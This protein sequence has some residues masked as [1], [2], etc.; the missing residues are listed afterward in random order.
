[1]TSHSD[2]DW[3]QTPIYYDM[4][5]DVGSSHEADFLVGA[6][7]KHHQLD[8]IPSPPF[9]LEPACGSGRLMI[10]MHRRGWQPHGFDAHPGMIDFARHRFRETGTKAKVWLDRMECFQVPGKARYPLAHCLV[11]TF[12]YLLTEHD[13]R[14]HLHAVGEVLLPGG[15]Y[16][17]GL[18]LSDYAR[19]TCEHERWTA[20]RDGM[21]V[22]CNIRGWPPNPKTREEKVRSRLAVTPA[23]QPVQRHE[24]SWIFRTYNA[25]QLKR[26]LG[27][28]ASVFDLVGCYDFTYDLSSPR[29][30]DDDYADILLVLR[31]REP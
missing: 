13:A 23:G 8:R 21:E 31:R 1:M 3:Y 25:A 22:V 18:H 26:T 27:S 4:I 20:T 24:T 19:T 2:F 29:R 7:E 9:V 10:E 6:W 5:F 15:I 30:L 28:V 17:L 12:K 14:A 16:L 11:S